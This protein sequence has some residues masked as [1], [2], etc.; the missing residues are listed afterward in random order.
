MKAPINSEKRIVQTTLSTVAANGQASVILVNVQQEPVAGTP[1]H[2]A[3]GTIVKAIYVEMWVLASAQQPST[4]T[5]IIVKSPN[6]VA[7][8]STSEF[9]DLNSWTNKNNI[10]Q[11]H[12]GLVGD[13]NSNPI[14][15]F[16]EWI[17]IPKGK[18]R[19]S[20]GDKIHFAIKGITDSTE[21]CGVTIF[22]AYN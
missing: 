9:A 21:F 20:I 5:G 14:P 13:A 1:S 7:S 6:G 16:R 11:M 3:V 15:I 18:Q 22:K 8:P 12:Q 2:V 19:M 17:K 10:L 4:M